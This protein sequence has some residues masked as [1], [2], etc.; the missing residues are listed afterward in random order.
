MN[1]DK[2]KI[3]ITG[4]TGFIG[5]NLVKKL[6]KD[7][8]FQLRCLIRKDTDLFKNNN[9][10]L[11]KGDI[12][13]PD[14]LKSICD[15]IDAV[16]H[17]SAIKHET[18]PKEEIYNTNVMG[19]KNLLAECTNIKHFIYISTW[20]TDKEDS[21]YAKT[22]KLGEDLVKKSKLNYTILRLSHVYS[23]EENT[24]ILKLYRMSK[25]LITG[26]AFEIE[27]IDIDDLCNIIPKVI[28]NKN[29]FNQTF[30]IGGKSKNYDNEKIRK[31]IG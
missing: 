10:E 8:Q 14:S 16:V 23:K 30:Y 20:L 7:G 22:K 27:P 13:Y 2:I 29:C 11:V 19:T 4:A 17:L 28:G 6:I 24:I 5:K 1:G 3:L 21:Y 15:G 12:R 25:K 26:K 18:E 9:V 31:I